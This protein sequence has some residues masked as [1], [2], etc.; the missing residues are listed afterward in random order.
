MSKNEFVVKTA[1]HN[2]IDGQSFNYKITNFDIER[3]EFTADKNESH[4][5]F[6]KRT[7]KEE[8]T[9]NP[10]E[11]ITVTPSNRIPAEAIRDMDTRRN[12]LAYA[13][14]NETNQENRANN[15]EP[16]SAP[17]ATATARPSAPVPNEKQL[18][19]ELDPR[20]A[21][22]NLSSKTFYDAVEQSKRFVAS[23]R[24]QGNPKRPEHTEW[25]GNR[26]VG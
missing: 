9:L 4:G 6:N 17:D 7:G 12:E 25:N 5:I 13:R 19:K 15:L 8:A 1:T 18:P 3:R 24:S 16:G 21:S 23:S 14:A 11:T 10:G 26:V 20:Y 22:S 2:C